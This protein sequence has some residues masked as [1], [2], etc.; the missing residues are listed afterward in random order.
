[1][2]FRKRE[3]ENKIIWKNCINREIQF[4][5]RFR[6]HPQKQRNLKLKMW[7]NRNNLMFNKLR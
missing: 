5:F 1:M 4:Q 2:N 3:L 7:F 6:Q